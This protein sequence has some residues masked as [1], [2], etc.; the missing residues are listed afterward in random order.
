MK[1]RKYVLIGFIILT[2]T[3][4]AVSCFGVNKF[5][6]LRVAEINS[7]F[8]FQCAQ[9]YRYTETLKNKAVVSYPMVKE[10][11]DCV[12]SKGKLN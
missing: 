6:A 9:T 5:Y 10:Y 2:A 11:K 3:L 1:N 4:A 12:N 7:E 8:D